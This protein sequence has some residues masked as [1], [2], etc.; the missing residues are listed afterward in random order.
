MEARTNFSLDASLFL[1]KLIIIVTSVIV[2]DWNGQHKQGCHGR[3]ILL[4]K[5]HNSL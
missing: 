2:S 1:S 4:K 5:I 3:F